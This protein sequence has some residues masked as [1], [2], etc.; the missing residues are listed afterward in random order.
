[1]EIFM[2]CVFE[3][4]PHKIKLYKNENKNFPNECFNE[5]LLVLEISGF[6]TRK[7]PS[8]VF[9]GCT[10]ALTLILIIY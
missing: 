6:L 8:S 5:K 3:E 7:T 10:S 9:Q 1:M 2:N 4:S